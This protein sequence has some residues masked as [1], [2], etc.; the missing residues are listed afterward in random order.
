MLVFIPLKLSKKQNKVLLIIVILIF[1]IGELY[2][3]YDYYRHGS[4][5]IFPFQ[6]CST[7]LYLLP[8]LLILPDKHE[9]PILTYLATFGLFAG[10]IT[11]I[12]PLGVFK[13][14]LLVSIHTMVHHSLMLWCG[15]Y[16]WKIKKEGHIKDF[17]KA[18]MILLIFIIIAISINILLNDVSSSRVR[19]FYLHPF[20]ET[21][22]PIYNYIQRVSF[23]LYVFVY[24]V[25]FCMAAV[26]IFSIGHFLNGKSQRKMFLITNDYTHIYK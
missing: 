8:L 14:R 25:T 13:D 16:I 11:L 4:W 22:L 18:C 15:I 17:I 21:S 26:I 20:V 23:I 24:Y 3:Q 12:Y 5:G 6:F 1:Y 2:K 10:L 9:Q 19:M 7:H